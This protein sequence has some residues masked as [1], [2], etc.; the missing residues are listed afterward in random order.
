MSVVQVGAKIGCSSAPY[1]CYPGLQLV[2]AH[3]PET[4]AILQESYNH[5]ALPLFKQLFGQRH[6][7]SERIELWRSGRLTRCKQMLLRT[8]Y[9][10]LFQ[11][12][13]P[14]NNV[15]LEQCVPV[16]PVILKFWGG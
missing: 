16:V 12:K 7:R 8:R 11:R 1:R 6:I 10:A 2:A 3:F 15:S 4:H 14:E 5:L 13:P 9:V